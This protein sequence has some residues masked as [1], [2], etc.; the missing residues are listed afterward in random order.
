MVLF[1]KCIKNIWTEL[2]QLSNCGFSLILLFFKNLS[3]LGATM[4]SKAE[5]I[6]VQQLVVEG[7]LRPVL[8]SVFEMAR[9]PE[10]LAR[11]ESR[12]VFGKVVVKT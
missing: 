10:A 2:F 11:L 12:Q 8:D 1:V 5:V 6:R 4:G 9:Y 7:K 3:I